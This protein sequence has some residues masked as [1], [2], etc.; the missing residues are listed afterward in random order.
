MDKAPLR[1]IAVVMDG[2]GRWAKNQGVERL[3]G[4]RKGAE[5]ALEI[6]KH[7]G[8]RG[9]P[10]LTLYTFSSEN[11]RRPEEEVQGLMHILYEK[12]LK[13]AGSLVENGVKLQT[14]GDVAKLPAHVQQALVDVKNM[15]RHC[16][17]L[18]LT[19]ALSYGAR[20]EIVRAAKKLAEEV[21]V[22]NLS[23]DKIDEGCFASFL[24]TASLP[25][26][27][28]IIRTSGENRLSNFLLWQS[29]YAEIFFLKMFWPDFQPTDLD[30]V[31]AEFVA[32]E[33]RFGRIEA[34]KDV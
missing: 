27:D 8:K 5:V 15:T 24:D 21:S 18:T 25:D 6:V 30:D 29:S 22:G 34:D 33:R 14:I 10:Y 26:P 4:H 12:L 28:V 9:V 13:E 32:R 2:N 23:V 20:D 11:W 16:A 3:E 1:H 17:K 31:L 7:A 19:L